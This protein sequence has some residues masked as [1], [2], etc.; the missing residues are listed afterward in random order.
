MVA[1]DNKMHFYRYRNVNSTLHIYWEK[2]I[3][4]KTIENGHLYIKIENSRL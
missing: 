1:T 4:P 2:S 3:Y